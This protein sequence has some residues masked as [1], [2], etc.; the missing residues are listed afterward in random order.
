MSYREA[1]L[2]KLNQ[3]YHKNIE[4]SNVNYIQGYGKFVSSKE[5]EVI[6]NSGEENSERITA[7]HILIATGS[8][9]EN[10]NFEGNELCWTSDDIFA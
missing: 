2:R 4:A 1:Y 8:T 3:I 5:I 7:D 10:G 9:P 6:K